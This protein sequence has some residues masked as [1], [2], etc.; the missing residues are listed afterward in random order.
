MEKRFGSPGL[1]SVYI[2]K[3]NSFLKEMASNAGITKFNKRYTNHSMQ[4]YCKEIAR[5]GFSNDKI[6][7]ITGHKSEQSLRDYTE[8]DNI[9]HKNMSHTLS[10]AFEIRKTSSSSGP[11]INCPSIPVETQ[12]PTHIFSHCSVNINY[13]TAH[14]SLTSSSLH[15]SAP[16]CKIMKTTE[17]DNEYLT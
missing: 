14:S 9:E 4:N 7:S 3:I 15:L 6:S 13:G 8:T 10:S 17:S 12:A 5:A 16:P 11:A 1:K 2:N